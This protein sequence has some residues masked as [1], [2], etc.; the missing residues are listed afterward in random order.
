MSRWFGIARGKW[1]A[2]NRQ[3]AE[4][5]SELGWSAEPD[6]MVSHILKL[7]GLKGFGDVDVLAWSHERGRVLVIECKY[8]HYRRTEGEIAE[9]LADFRGQPRSSGKPGDLLKH[10]NRVDVIS[11]NLPALMK[12]VG[13]DQPPKIES[14]LVF[15]H[16]VPMQFAWE[17]MKKRVLLHTFAEL[18]AV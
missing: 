18:A 1:Q 10:L 5:L 17:R 7:E 4:R 15:R 3:V 6:V 13:I 14:H 8:L 11:Q 9:Q 2:F 16:A 12:F